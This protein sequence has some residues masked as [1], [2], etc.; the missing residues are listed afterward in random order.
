MSNINEHINKLREDFIKGTLSENEVNANPFIQFE[1]WFNQA[2]HAKIAEPQA[3]TL[4]TC[5]KNKPSSRI[6]YLREL[7]DNQF[8]FYTV[9]ACFQRV[10]C[11]YPANQ[12]L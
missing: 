8:W 3:M 2:I 11:S 9:Q 4:S 10:M 12:D 5:S 1:T 6:V 7:Q